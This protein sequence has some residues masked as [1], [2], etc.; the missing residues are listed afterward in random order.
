MPIPRLDEFTDEEFHSQEANLR[1]E[2]RADAAAFGLTP[3]SV[4]A[5]DAGGAEWGASYGGYLS[6]LSGVHAA[7]VK[8]DSTRTTYTTNLKSILKK[9]DLD[10]NVSADKKA[11]AGCVPKGPARKTAVKPMTRPGCRIELRNPLQHTIH[12]FDELTPLKKAKPAGMRGARIYVKV[13]GKAPTDQHTC[14]YLATDTTTPYVNVFSPAERGKTAYY[15][16]FWENTHGEV[17]PIS[18]LFSAVVA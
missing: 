9:I 7:K 18:E 10:P 6:A 11:A 3:A 15:F 1:N 16:L 5:L 14:T 4:A 12:F 8:K 13:G 2:L 17:G